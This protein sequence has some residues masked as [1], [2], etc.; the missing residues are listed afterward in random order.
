[1]QNDLTPPCYAHTVECRIQNAGQR[2]REWKSNSK[3]LNATKGC[4]KSLTSFGVKVASAKEI[5][6]PFEKGLLF[7]TLRKIY[8]AFL[9]RKAN[10]SWQGLAP[11]YFSHAKREFNFL[12]LVLDFL[13]TRL[14][15]WR[16]QESEKAHDGS[17][18]S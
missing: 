16:A 12:T 6:T 18:L 2:L 4:K 10:I 15:G 5:L 7:I 13:K 8:L 17:L 11:C 3:E 14:F 9:V 1:M